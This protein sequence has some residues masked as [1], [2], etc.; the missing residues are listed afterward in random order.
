MHDACITDIYKKCS[1][2]VNK[3]TEYQCN[4]EVRLSRRLNESDDMMRGNC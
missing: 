2:L 1:E 4:E 3:V